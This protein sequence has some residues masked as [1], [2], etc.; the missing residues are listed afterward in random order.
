[1]EKRKN[2]LQLLG[3]CKRPDPAKPTNKPAGANVPSAAFLG[4]FVGMFG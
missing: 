4:A 3:R 1:M 2:P